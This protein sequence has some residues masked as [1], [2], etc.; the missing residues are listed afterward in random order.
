MST[1]TSTRWP[2][3]GNWS[4][5][6]LVLTILTSD[7]LTESA[8]MTYSRDIHGGEMDIESCLGRREVITGLSLV[9]LLWL[10]FR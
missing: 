2:V 7:W 3:T 1:N 5:D 6:W 4:S 8:E 10:I 9:T